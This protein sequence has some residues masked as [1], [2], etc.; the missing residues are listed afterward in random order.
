M[1]AMLVSCARDNPL[2]GLSAGQ[3]GGGEGTG[4]GND[5]LVTSGPSEGGDS[6]AAGVSATGSSDGTSPTECGNGRVEADEECDDDREFCIECRELG[7][8][9]WTLTHDGAAGFGDRFEAVVLSDDQLVVV[10]RGEAES[11]P[12]PN[13]VGVLAI[14]DPELG[15]FA[16]G[17]LELTSTPMGPLDGSR[18]YDLTI[19]DDTVYAAGGVNLSGDPNGSTSAIVVYDIA[20]E[21]A[22]VGVYVEFEGRF[23]SSIASD[24][25]QL[26]IGVSDFSQGAYGTGAVALDGSDPMSWLSSRPAAHESNALT[27]L[28]SVVIL[29]GMVAGQP[30]LGTSS[31]GQ[32]P[33]PLP[34]ASLEVSGRVRGM[35]PLAPDLIVAGG[36]GDEGSRDPWI[37]RFA[38][39]GTEE[40]SAV[41]DG[42]QAGELA[43]VVLDGGGNIVAVGSVGDPSHGVVA[44]FEPDGTYVAAR[45]YDDL[46]DATEFNGALYSAAHTSLFIVGEAPA[47]PTDTDAIILRVAWIF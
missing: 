32:Q 36:L 2:F 1:L 13:S 30:F 43:D 5:D 9:E 34:N 37:G 33:A 23:A 17:P 11:G 26:H 47:D 25:A 40:W 27:V 45:V 12:S 38:A 39:D 21:P 35:V 22:V 28:G 42:G 6:T 4:D 7:R 20:V 24:G 3:T 10:G 8:V 41:F 44:V 19:D 15:V 46:G 16:G 31:G 29:G 14:V 18:L